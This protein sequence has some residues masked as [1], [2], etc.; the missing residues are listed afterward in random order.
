MRSEYLTSVKTK[1][2]NPL[3]QQEEPYL[4]PREKTLRVIAS[5]T[6]VLTM[7]TAVLGAVF[8]VIIFRLFLLTAMY[9]VK[10]LDKFKMTKKNLKKRLICCLLQTTQTDKFFAK[11]AKLVATGIAASLN[12]V[13][14]EVS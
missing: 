6:I 4:Q 8:S 11:Y 1:R 14:I 7:L 13:V 3:S 2:L 5:G 9:Q 12:A 10:H